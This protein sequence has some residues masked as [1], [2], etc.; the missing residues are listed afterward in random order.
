MRAYKEPSTV[1]RAPVAPTRSLRSSLRLYLASMM[2]LEE[3]L[4]GKLGGKQPLHA[5]VAFLGRV[6]FRLQVSLHSQR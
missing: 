4:G 2:K 1:P 6:C 3:L 5:Q